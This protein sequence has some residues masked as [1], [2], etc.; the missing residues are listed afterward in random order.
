M[1]QEDWLWCSMMGALAVAALLIAKLSAIALDWIA[2]ATT[3][4]AW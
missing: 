3:A 4:V 2:A 1:D